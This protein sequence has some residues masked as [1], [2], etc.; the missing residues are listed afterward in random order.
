MSD[1][2]I[3]A[4]CIVLIRAAN[5]LEHNEVEYETEPGGCG[6]CQ[7]TTV[8]MRRCVVAIVGKLRTTEKEA[9]EWPPEFKVFDDELRDE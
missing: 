3:S 6:P 2:R 5:S 9:C 1:Y 7:Y 8:E 4:K